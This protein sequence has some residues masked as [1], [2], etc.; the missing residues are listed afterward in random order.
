MSVAGYGALSAVERT[1]LSHGSDC[2]RQFGQS[3]RVVAGGGHLHPESVALHA[4]VAQF[5][6]A[7]HR[8]RPAKDLFNTFPDP[9]AEAIS[10]V[11]SGVPVNGRALL[12]G[13][14]GCGSRP[15][16]SLDE[17]P[18]VVAPVGPTVIW[19]AP[20]AASSISNGAVRSQAPSAGVRRMSATHP[21][22]LSIKT[23]APKHRFASFLSPF[24]ASLAGG[25]VADRW[26]S[27]LRRP[28]WHLARDQAVSVL[29]EFLV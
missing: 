17:A 26:V 7:S 9:L 8:L 23:W 12:L 13:Y 25:S 11:R 27:L 6:A 28:P 19:L 24:R 2:R 29:V 3:H 5:A 15:P 21:S 16:A 10:L 14:V 4:A 1:D 22:R 18:S 20:G